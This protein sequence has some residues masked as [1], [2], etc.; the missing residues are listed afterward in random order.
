MWIPRVIKQDN[1]GSNVR[2]SRKKMRCLRKIISLGGTSP[3]VG[4]ELIVES[5]TV[6]FFKS[7]DFEAIVDSNH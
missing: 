7:F 6:T 5:V 4:D 3:I 2:V 1:V